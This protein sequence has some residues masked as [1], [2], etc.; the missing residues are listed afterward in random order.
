[1]S[2][3]VSAKQGSN[4]EYEL[5]PAGNHLAICFQMIDLGEQYNAKYDSWQHKVQIGWELP[6]ELMADGRPFMVSS[7]YTMSLNEKAILRR[8]L[9]SW[10][11]RPFTP[12]E[13]AGFDLKNVVGKP[14]MVNVVHNPV[15]D[16][17][18]ANIKSVAAIPK[19]MT[20]PDQINDSVI[21]EIDQTNPDLEMYYS[22]PEFLQK[23]IS[24]SRT[25]QTLDGSSQAL[26]TSA[27]SGEPED[28]IPF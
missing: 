1:M 28:D 27:P 3:T 15:G 13:E 23:T 12:E 9:E 17:T 7:R 26:D 5:A 21:F 14:C 22:L 8:D 24:E 18:Y 4:K 2:L 19:G 16:R 11:G 25:W 10:R 6:N 20:I